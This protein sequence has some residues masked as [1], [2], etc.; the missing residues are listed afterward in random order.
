MKIKISTDKE[1]CKLMIINPEKD[2]SGDWRCEANG[3]PTYCTLSV[4]RTLFRLVSLFSTD[5]FVAPPRNYQWVEKM[6]PE[7]CL[8][9]TKECQL[10]VKL[11]E[12]DAPL[13][14]YHGDKLITVFN[15]VKNSIKT[16]SIV[17]KR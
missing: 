5:I 1:K 2:D 4:T 15:R 11:N 9:R 17:A 3:V 14:W 16:V 13:E 6:L 12:K 8:T 7:T 10:T